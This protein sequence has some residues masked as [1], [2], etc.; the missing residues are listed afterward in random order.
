MAHYHKC[1]PNRF[2]ICSSANILKLWVSKPI[3]VIFTFKISPRSLIFVE[4]WW[5]YKNIQVH[6]YFQYCFYC[7]VHIFVNICPNNMFLGSF[8]TVFLGLLKWGPVQV[9]SRS[10]PLTSW[11]WTYY[12]G[13]VRV[14]TRVR[15]VQDQPFDSLAKCR[16]W[17]CMPSQQLCTW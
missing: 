8:W 1:F 6:N 5:N 12:L 11:T 9:R 4:I 16:H 13:P 17:W 7:F 15:Q 14:Q 10:G 2:K 3:D